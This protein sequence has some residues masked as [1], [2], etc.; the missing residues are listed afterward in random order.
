MAPAPAPPPP[1]ASS[2]AAS[3][4]ARYEARGARDA[5]VARKLFWAG[6]ACLPWL[7][8]L[9]LLHYRAK[10]WDAR[11]HPA[12]RWYL[13]AQ[14]CGLVLSTAAFVAWVT[15][16]QMRWRGWG[17]LGTNLLIYV[18]DTRWWLE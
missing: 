3:A 17:D 6:C 4:A 16:F 13:R 14:A 8:V 10:L 15:V 1:G 2:A 12:L 7:W 11:T 5:A 9:C 18:P